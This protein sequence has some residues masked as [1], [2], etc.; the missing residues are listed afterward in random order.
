MDI[1]SVI[2]LTTHGHCLSQNFFLATAL[3]RAGKRAKKGV[4]KEAKQNLLRVLMVAQ[5]GKYTEG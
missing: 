4:G 2:I 1:A 5:K 3:R